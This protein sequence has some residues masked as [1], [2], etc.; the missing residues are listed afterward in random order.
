MLNRFGRLNYWPE[1]IASFKN[2]NFFVLGFI[3]VTP[4]AIIFYSLVILLSLTLLFFI[5]MIAF[6]LAYI[7]EEKYKRYQDEVWEPLILSFLTGEATLLQLVKKLKLKSR[8]RYYFAEFISNYLSALAG[9][10]C[11]KLIALLKAL[12]FTA[13]E[14]KRL[15]KR[16]VWVRVFALI[17]LATIK[18]EKAIPDIKRSLRDPLPIISFA[19]A[20]AL[21]SLQDIDSFDEVASVLLSSKPWNRIRAAEIFLE[22]GRPAV[23]KLLKFLYDPAVE[24][25]RKALIIDVITEFKYDKVADELLRLAIETPN[26]DIKVSIIKYLGQIS[27]LDAEDFLTACL[28]NKNWVIRSQ[29]AKSLG[30]VGDPEKVNQLAHLLKDE[31]WWVRYHA[32]NALGNIGPEGWEILKKVKASSED[33]YAVDIS[34]QI[35][36][37]LNFND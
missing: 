8:D 12:N 28:S 36:D 24:E 25:T 37:E 6:R 3:S 19:A 5:L 9:E 15:K 31:V 4:G 20:Q 23:G 10:E 11:D 22:Y 34:A 16:N 35:L 30:L 21:A 13:W 14:V 1:S 2:N 29:A 26:D 32:A 27:Y 7:H 18:D 17:H 33:K